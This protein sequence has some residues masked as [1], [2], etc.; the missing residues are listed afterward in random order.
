MARRVRHTH[1]VVSLSSLSSC[2]FCLMS[3][4]RVSNQKRI[5]VQ[6]NGAFIA[7]DASDNADI[8]ASTKFQNKRYE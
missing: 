5:T 3:S 1:S 6:Q 7:A 4:C 2:S 8:D